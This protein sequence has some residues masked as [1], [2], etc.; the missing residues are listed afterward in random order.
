[1]EI[2]GP[3]K[4]VQVR[5]RNVS[6]NETTRFTTRKK[7]RYPMQLDVTP[8]ALAAASGQIAALTGRLVAVNTSHMVANH[9]IMPPGSD[10]A[11]IKTAASLQ[12]DGIEHDAM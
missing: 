10:I 4:L 7:G 11:S 1:M 6:N 2:A 3:V 8:E 12:A 9:M 5:P